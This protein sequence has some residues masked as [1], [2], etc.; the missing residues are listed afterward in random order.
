MQELKIDKKTSEAHKLSQLDGLVDY[1]DTDS[2]SDASSGNDAHPDSKLWIRK[3]MEKLRRHRSYDAI[4][5][6]R[7]KGDIDWHKRVDS[8][9]AAMHRNNFEC[10]DKDLYVS[11]WVTNSTSPKHSPKR[12]YDEAGLIEEYPEWGVNQWQDST[13]TGA[14]SAPITSN[15]TAEASKTISTMPPT[16]EMEPEIMSN[17]EIPQ[18]KVRAV[19]NNVSPKRIRMCGDDEDSMTDEYPQV[20]IMERD[21]RVL[22]VVKSTK[23]RDQEQEETFND[24]VE[25]LLKKHGAYKVQCQWQREISKSETTSPTQRLDQVL[26]AW[27]A[28]DIVYRNP[29]LHKSL[30][31][32]ED[33]LKSIKEERESLA[34]YEPDADDDRILHDIHE[35]ET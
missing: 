17:K 3:E 20:T 18:P 10:W 22:Y 33:K 30:W 19:E 27:S 4:V 28:G 31:K 13:A 32:R 34:G 15:K 23:P 21:M 29:F 2:T 26:E 16:C 24:T 1:S 9:I 8:I 5:N 7:E 12:T 25:S 14:T 6:Y 11:N 35:S